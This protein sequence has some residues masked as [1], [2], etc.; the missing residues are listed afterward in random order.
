MRA[1]LAL[2]LAALLGGAAE[3]RQQKPAKL[4]EAEAKRLAALIPQLDSKKFSERE[5][6]MKALDA[7]GARGLETLEKAAKMPPPS[8]RCAGGSAC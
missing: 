4:S 5:R 8:W 1:T 6:A 3:A 2:A 7:F